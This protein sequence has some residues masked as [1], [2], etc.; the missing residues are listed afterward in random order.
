M[1]ALLTHCCVTVLS[2]MIALSRALELSL[3]SE[4]EALEIALKESM[5]PGRSS[6]SSSS[7]SVSFAAGSKD[8]SGS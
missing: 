8:F 4:Q 2:P 6:N 3:L 1:M 5:T 7:S